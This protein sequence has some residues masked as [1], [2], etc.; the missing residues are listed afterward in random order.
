ML[1]PYP[2]TEI[3]KKYVRS[4]LLPQTFE[5][6]ADFGRYNFSVDWYTEEMKTIYER[7]YYSS[8]FTGKKL[9]EHFPRDKEL[10]EYTTVLT[11]KWRNFDFYDNNE[12][13]GLMEKGKRM[14]KKLFG[15][16]AY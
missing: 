12:W 8:K 4:N 7:I 13:L 15:E 3:A 10:E 5:A 1:V 16:D 2:G 6:W 14:L 9:L 11:R